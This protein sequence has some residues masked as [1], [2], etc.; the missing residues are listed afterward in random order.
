MKKT[1]EIDIC[2]YENCCTF[3]F[4]NARDRHENCTNFFTLF[5]SGLGIDAKD[6]ERYRV[7]VELIQAERKQEKE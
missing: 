6:G 3:E 5:E 1:I 2:R 4:E 7:T